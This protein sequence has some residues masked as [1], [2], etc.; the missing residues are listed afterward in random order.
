MIVTSNTVTSINF[1]TGTW[2]IELGMLISSL[3][4]VIMFAEVPIEGNKTL[5]EDNIYVGWFMVTFH[6]FNLMIKVFQQFKKNEYSYIVHLLLLADC[7]TYIWLL[8]KIAQAAYDY[9][10]DATPKTI[11]H[12]AYQ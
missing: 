2:K 5:T 7:T 9:R 1:V 8:L 6:V 3:Y 4:V 10:L 12:Q 11:A